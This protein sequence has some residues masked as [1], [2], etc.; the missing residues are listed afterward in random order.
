M[1]H[2]QPVE[3]TYLPH[4]RLTQQ[5][6][7]RARP[8]RRTLKTMLPLPCLSGGVRFLWTFALCLP[9]L[10]AN[11]QQNGQA[12]QH[13]WRPPFGLERVGAGPAESGV[14]AAATASPDT[15][16][17]PADL[18]TVFVPEGWLTLGPG[19]K[20]V[21][22]VAA[23]SHEADLTDATVS[24]WFGS[25]PDAIHREAFPLAKGE[26]EDVQFV[27]DAPDL[28]QVD[29]KLRVAI[30]SGGKTVWSTELPVMLIASPPE[31][32]EFGA[33]EL[34]LR[35]D[36]PILVNEAEDGKIVLDRLISKDYKTGWDEE[37]NDVV[38]SLPNGS[39]FV[40]W[41][42][43]CYIPFWAGPHNT[44][45][46]YE[47]AETRPP[48]GAFVDSIEPLMDKELRYGDVE[49]IESTPARVHV[50]WTYQSV[51]F[52]YEIFGDQAVEDYY[53]YPDGFA[54]RS[55][56]LKKRPE[57]PYELTEFIVLSAAGMYPLGFL[58]RQAAEMFYLDNGERYDFHFPPLEY[59]RDQGGAFEFTPPRPGSVL[60]R[61]R[62]HVEDAASAIYFHP[63][64]AHFPKLQ[65]APFFD[66]DTLVTPG[67]WGSHWPLARGKMTG[68]A[69]DPLITE[70]PSHTSLLTW[71]FDNEPPPESR[72]VVRTLDASGRPREMAVEHYAW[73]IGMSDADP[74][75]LL[76]VARSYTTP[77]EISVEG[78]TL[79]WDG[80][81][82]SRRAIRLRADAD[83]ISVKI[84]PNPVTVN[85]VFEIAGA[86]ENLRSVYLDDVLLP[87][88]RYAWD[89]KTL[90][91]EATLQQPQA[92]QIDFN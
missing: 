5:H 88:A 47:W 28:E 60:Y 25:K 74:E 85:P 22:E 59:S 45:L 3:T 62:T 52:K 14:E 24:A 86:P 71:A 56:R 20:P 46:C 89:G 33:T 44:A 79:E 2:W 84:T 40:F 6:G 75:R 4:T 34:K 66:G 26:R 82:R 92:L 36:L 69:I 63:S 51:S 16:V 57:A 58:P 81:Q 37:L 11:A 12:E 35:Y 18:G 64:E 21:V 39:R 50:R 27:L 42:G 31:L 48:P 19:Q 80:Y 91:I 68:G 73:L 55:L 38:V 32:P 8:P 53:F 76:D 30:R 15:R 72:G 43:A 54:T 61:I 7:A 90:W 70:T 87:S 49:V 67:Y 17:H 10:Q 41:R 65:F 77:P 1:R 23:V 78:A 13:S 83:R 9:A 29:D